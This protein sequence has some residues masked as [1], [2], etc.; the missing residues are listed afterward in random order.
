KGM[1]DN[2]FVEVADAFTFSQNVF[3]RYG[4]FARFYRPLLGP[5][6][7][8]V[9][10]QS[11]VITSREPQGGPITERYI[12]GGINDIRG[13]RLRTL[14]PV[15]FVQNPGEPGPLNALQLGGNL[16]IIFNSEIEFPLFQKVGISG[17]VFFDAGNAYNLEDKWCNQEASAAIRLS[18]KVD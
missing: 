14:S 15:V 5:F 18:P 16:E 7:L 3:V 1:W 13:F 2:L 12:L 10:L 11:E 17:V 4:G 6:V 8:K 9:N